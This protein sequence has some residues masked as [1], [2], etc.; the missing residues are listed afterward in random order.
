MTNNTHFDYFRGGE[1]TQYQ[2][3]SMPKALM[4]DPRFKGLSNDAKLLYTL[5]LD[6]MGLSARNGWYDQGRVYIYFTLN[7]VQEVLN[8]G[9]DKGMRILAELDTNKGVG[10]IE[11]VKQGQGK[12]T[13][14]FVKRFTTEAVPA[15]EAAGPD[16]DIPEY[17][18]EPAIGFSGWYTTPVS[19]A[20]LPGYSRA[21]YA[22]PV[23]NNTEINKTDFIQTD[24]S[25]YQSRQRSE[26]QTGGR[27]TEAAADR[28]SSLPSE[29]QTPPEVKQRTAPQTVHPAP[30]EQAGQNKSHRETQ[31]F[32]RKRPA[33]SP[34]PGSGAKCAA[35]S[36]SM[37]FVTQTTL[38]G[39]KAPKPPK[40]VPW[41]A[42]STAHRTEARL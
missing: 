21:D 13:K 19:D 11:R 10:L 33:E 26:K 41:D 14:I 7:E 17:T 18:R 16:P 6:R 8:C 9:S 25:I 32:D 40:C 4:K 42:F 35:A 36:A 12:P 27:R 28:E 38:V 39:G 23:C 34:H 2:F 15:P 30:R 31:F 37:S 24:R 22:K 1:S 29:Q 5:M 3:Y 20:V